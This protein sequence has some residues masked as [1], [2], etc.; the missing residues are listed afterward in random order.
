MIT[1]EVHC[2]YVNCCDL[3]PLRRGLL[4]AMYVACVR[5]GASLSRRPEL[6]PFSVGGGLGRG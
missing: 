5:P 4:R 2:Y 1:L 3:F 6:G